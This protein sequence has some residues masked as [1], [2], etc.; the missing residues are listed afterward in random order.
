M[1]KQATIKDY[2]LETL[3]PF[4][5]LLNN[6]HLSLKIDDSTNHNIRGFQSQ[7]KINAYICTDFK[8]YEEILFHLMA[9]ACK[10][11]PENSRIEIA[12]KL[13]YEIVA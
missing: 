10:F 2:L 8:I 9:N 3:K 11:S 1:L 5:F 7:E 13:K 4:K 12:V 6:K